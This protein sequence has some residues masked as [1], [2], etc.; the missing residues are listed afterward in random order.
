MIEQLE[1]TD[2]LEDY[3]GKWAALY[4]FAGGIKQ[5]ANSYE[6]EETTQSAIEESMSVP[7]DV[8][9][10]EMY[11]YWPDGFEVWLCDIITA[12]PI[13]IGD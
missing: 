13:P 9:E 12:F 11:L 10:W 4:I 7:D 2:E 1:K 8:E 3:K 6:S 5:G